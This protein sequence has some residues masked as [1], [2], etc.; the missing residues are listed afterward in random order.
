MAEYGVAAHWAYKKGALKGRSTARIH[1]EMN[2]SRRWWSSKTRLMDAVRNLWT[3]LKKTIWRRDLRLPYPPDG[4]VR[5]FQKIQDRSTCL[6]EIH[7]KVG[8]KHQ[9]VNGRMV[10]LTNCSRQDQAEIITNPN[11][12]GPSRWLAQ[13]GQTSKARNKIQN[14]LKIKTR[15]YPQ[16]GRDADAAQF[17]KRLCS[18]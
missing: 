5:P 4:A 8:W 7:T 6:C 2:W 18:Q 11:S 17:K 12:F 13:H 3:L 14:A 16:Q 15:N 1:I 10:P 9:S